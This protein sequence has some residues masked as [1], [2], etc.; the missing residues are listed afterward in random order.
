[1]SNDCAAVDPLCIEP[2]PAPRETHAHSRENSLKG[3]TKVTTKVLRWVLFS[4]AGLAFL[5]LPASVQAADV[6]VDCTGGPADFSSVTDALNAL[7]HQGPHTITIL[8]GN[9]NERIQIVDRERLTIT[10]VPIGSTFVSP[11][12]GEGDV[13]RVDNSRGITLIQIG[14]TAGVN[15]VRIDR[16]SEVTLIGCSI[17]GNTNGVL[18][19]GQSLFTAIGSV[20]VSNANNG[21]VVRNQ[22]LLNA[23]G[24]LF[25]GNGNVGLVV[26]QGSTAIAG[27]FTPGG[28]N[29]FNGNGQRG[30]ACLR[31]CTLLLNSFNGFA[32]NGFAGLTVATGSR[33]VIDGSEGQNEFRD[34]GSGVLV[35]FGSQAVFAGPNSIHDNP[36]VGV[37]ADENSSVFLSELTVQN[38]GQGGVNALRM[39][40]VGFGGSNAISGNGGANVSCDST[41][42]IYGDLTGI[43]N[44]NC[45]RIERTL[46]PPRPGR[47]RE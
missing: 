32:N 1:M 11:E 40:T 17:G 22:S 15:G 39:A 35:F 24:N 6:T 12:P 42:L 13:I 3:E 8:A 25:D 5:L 33:A 4:L 27:D 14:A 43:T 34:N 30:I 16:K 9:C 38:N 36:G 7:D 41:A 21:V 45:S 2:N 20:F 28:G 29:N 26:R 46:G 19:T 10:A 18:V 37:E 23:S 47:V 44:I 31:G